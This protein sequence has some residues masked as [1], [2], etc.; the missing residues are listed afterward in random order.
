V[1][2]N[3]SSFW[4][5][6]H[7]GNRIAFFN[8][9]DMSLTEY[10]VPTRDPLNGYIANVLTLAVDPNNNNK[11]WFTE[12]NHDKLG[13][14]DRSP[15]IPFSISPSASPITVL[16]ALSSETQKNA[17]LIAATL[18]VDVTTKSINSSSMINNTSHALLFLHASSSMNPLGRFVNMTTNFYPTPIIDLTKNGSGIAHTHLI[19]LRNDFSPI[20]PGNYTVGISATDGSVTKSIFKDLHVKKLSEK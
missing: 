3:G 8:T 13:V 12:F 10:E 11:K 7:I 17:S 15:P 20:F 6:E 1:G 9:T 2:T 4:F 18:N 19:L 14:V 16:S 5:N